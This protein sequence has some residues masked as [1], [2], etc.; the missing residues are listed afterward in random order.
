MPKIK[1]QTKDP[2]RRP[3]DKLKKT[4]TQALRAKRSAKPVKAK[5]P[6]NTSTAPK[7]QGMQACK[8]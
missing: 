1:K 4:E 5:K 6:E 7:A 3:E 8:C 2:A